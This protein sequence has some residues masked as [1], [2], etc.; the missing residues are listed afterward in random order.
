MARK[1]R[2]P[3]HFLSNS[4][5]PWTDGHYGYGNGDLSNWNF[6]CRRRRSTRTNIRTKSHG[7]RFLYKQNNLAENSNIDKNSKFSQK[8]SQNFFYKIDF[9][10]GPPFEF[11]FQC[12]SQSSIKN[13]YPKKEN[14]AQGKFVWIFRLAANFL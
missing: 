4:W 8:N 11:A 3:S 1:A 12:L 9:S 14:Y 6:H 13:L 10:F 5:T 2:F 7:H